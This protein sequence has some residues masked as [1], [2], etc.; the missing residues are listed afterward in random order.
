MSELDFRR[1]SLAELAAGVRSKAVSARELVTHALSRI[2]ALNPSINAFVA[3]DGERALDEAARIDEAVARDPDALGPLVGIPI[4]VKDNEDAAGF[5]T[6]SGSATRAGGPVAARDSVH[7]ARLRAAGCIVLGKTNMPEFGLRGET[8]N[9]TF[10]I[11]RNPWSHAHT[12]GGSSGGSAAAIAAGMVPLA[13]GSD[14][15]G[16]IRIPSAVCG[17]TGLKPTLGRVPTADPAPPGWPNLSTKGPMARRAADVALALDAVVGPHPLDHRS[18]PLTADVG[19]WG[20]ATALAS[21]VSGL[22]IAWPPNLGYAEVDAEVLSVC[23]GLVDLAAEAGAEVVE[24][25]TVFDGDPGVH[26]GVL[27]QN[28]I[29]RTVEPYRG[30][31]WWAQL[32]PL[33]I[34]AAELASLVAKDALALVRAEDACHTT[35]LQLATAMEGFDLLLAP[36]TRA[37]TAACERP[38]TVDELLADFASG[39]LAEAVGDIGLDVEAV[40]RIVESVRAA[41]PLNMPAGRC[42]DHEV[43][44]WHGMTQAFNMT[45]NPAGTTC[46]G[47]TAEG[48]PVGIQVVGRQHDD[49]GVLRALAALEHLA[50]DPFAAAV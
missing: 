1:T 30:T 11:T 18:L 16:S 14:G 4:A 10:G 50:G 21:G 24:L 48:L 25:D 29:R 13:T 47:F 37:V 28:Y 45:R 43:F 8:D 32:D 23:R 6:T 35:N 31:D 3:V 46:A 12:P 33:V 34:V 19:S 38:T 44:E 2:D 22:R 9:R 39:G 42:N 26:L 36:M 49:V 20:S 17:L 27:V 15:G 40:M 5:V 41:G 7:V